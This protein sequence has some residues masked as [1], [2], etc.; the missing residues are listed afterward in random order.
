MLV[1]ELAKCHST[2]S[3]SFFKLREDEVVLRHAGT[4]PK[5]TGR[6]R[7]REEEVRVMS[8]SPA[9]QAEAVLLL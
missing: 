3:R 9:Y 1:H 8:L 2:V 5:K 4:D 7:T 6:G